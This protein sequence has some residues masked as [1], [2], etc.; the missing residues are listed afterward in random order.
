MGEFKPFSAPDTMKP[1]T[2]G[3]GGGG[4]GG[5]RRRV[6]DKRKK[7]NKGKDKEEV[8]KKKRIP[9]QEKMEMNNTINYQ[10]KKIKKIIP[11]YS[12]ETQE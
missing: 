2:G 6:G 1:R 5:R 3:G 9:N 4:G 8:K 10:I 12:S 7:E 11:T